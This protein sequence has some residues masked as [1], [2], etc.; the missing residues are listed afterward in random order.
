MGRCGVSVFRDEE[1]RRGRRVTAAA[2]VAAG[3]DAR[4][5]SRVI[6]A[7]SS[8]SSSSSKS[9]G[10]EAKQTLSK[11]GGAENGV[12]EIVAASD[13]DGDGEGLAPAKHFVNLKNGIEA[14]PDLE[15]L[16]VSYDFMRI[17]STMCEVGDMARR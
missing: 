4:R 6:A 17:Q 2:M 5:R 3:R 16:G 1:E 11:T 7:Q 13:G 14:I 12:T 8:N 15:E 10:D 9:S